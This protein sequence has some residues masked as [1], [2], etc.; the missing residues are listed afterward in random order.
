[1]LD[2]FIGNIGNDTVKNRRMSVMLKRIAAEAA[3]E[4]SDVPPEIIELYFTQAAGVMYWAAT[5][6]RIYNIPLP[7]GFEVPA[8]LSL[9]NAKPAIENTESD[10][11]S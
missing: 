11:A 6:E 1:M 9:V 10:N 8:E 7:N 2:Y 5:G 3:D 4:M